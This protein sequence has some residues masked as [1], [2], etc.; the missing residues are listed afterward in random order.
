LEAFDAKRRFSLDAFETLPKATVNFVRTVRLSV[1]VEELGSHLRDF[2]GILDMNILEILS[3]K[4]RF[5]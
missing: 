3:R 2:R 5:D 4:F 1:C